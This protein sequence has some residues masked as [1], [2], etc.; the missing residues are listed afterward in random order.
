VAATG[1]VVGEGAHV[2]A[3]EPHAEVLALTAAGDAARGGTLYVTLEPC[4]HHGRTPPCTAA[5]AASGVAR[6]VVAAQ[7]PDGR[8]AGRG[9]GELRHAGVA[10]EPDVAPDEGE[11]LDPGYFH[12]RRTG[13][14]LVTLKLAATLDGQA[15][16][17]D[18]TSQWLTG[19]DARADAHRLR[20]WAD[21]V[22]IG[23][24]TLRTDDPRLD[25]RLPDYDG[26]QP[27]PVVVAGTSALPA[28][29]QVW[30]RSP[31]VYRAALGGDE[32]QAAEVVTLPNTAGVDLDAVIKDL[33]SRGI[34]DLLVEGGPTLA[35][36]LVAG[37]LVDRLV[38]YLAAKLA[39]GRGTPMIAGVFS[40]LAA[41]HP[42]E[43]VDVAMLG[44]DLRVDARL[45]GRS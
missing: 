31:L 28:T 18:R 41:A 3:G 23:A 24:G 42:I 34:L 8:V 16:A 11:A 14:P 13:R 39:G 21:A 17:A 26:P 36:Q 15:A 6:V 30:G 22:M 2:R 33:G 5:I 27:R 20:A 35:A 9:I 7:D 40:T 10:V 29:A 43:I 38:V 25:V 19:P 32:P 44:G 4:A 12:H 37:G 1:E 45:E